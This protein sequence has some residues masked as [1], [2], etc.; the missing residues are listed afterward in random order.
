MSGRCKSCNT[1]LTEDEMC[2][3]WPGTDDYC[4]LCS[5]CQAKSDPDED[6]FLELEE[7]SLDD[8]CDE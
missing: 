4:E 7:L 6:L 1:I 8:D 5:Y 3:K 2:A